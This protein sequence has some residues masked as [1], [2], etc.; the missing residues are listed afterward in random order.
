[1]RQPHE[2]AKTADFLAGKTG[3]KVV[4]LAAS[5]GAVPQAKDYIALFDYNT[6]TLASALR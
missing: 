4:L 5:V 1:M 3:A 2:P 6:E